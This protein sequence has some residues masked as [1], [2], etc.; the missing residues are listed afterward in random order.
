MSDEHALSLVGL[1]RDDD[2]VEAGDGAEQRLG[3]CGGATGPLEERNMGEGDM[4][5]HSTVNRY[6]MGVLQRYTAV[7]GAVYA[8]RRSRAL[9]DCSPTLLALVQYMIVALAPRRR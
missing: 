8:D 2:D 3:A 4:K 9:H 6:E 7:L 1:I 5:T